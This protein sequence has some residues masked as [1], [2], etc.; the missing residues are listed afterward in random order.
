MEEEKVIIT[1][2]N[3]STKVRIPIKESLIKFKCSNCGELYFALLGC[4]VPNPE[5][6]K[7]N[8]ELELTVQNNEVNQKEKIK[9]IDRL[10][11]WKIV[12]I[13]SLLSVIVLLIFLSQQKNENKDQQKILNN[14]TNELLNN[15]KDPQKR[16]FEKIKSMLTDESKNIFEMFIESQFAY[17]DSTSINKINCFINSLQP[18]EFQTGRQFRYINS[19][20]DTNYFKIDYIPNGDSYLI[21]L[22]IEDFTK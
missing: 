16:N 20:N 14:L 8:P 7:I 9:I 12:S 17:N 3:C 4:L 18:L 19:T 22:N 10:A 1:C 6:S 2:D 5:E 11:F 15:L 21:K 13:V